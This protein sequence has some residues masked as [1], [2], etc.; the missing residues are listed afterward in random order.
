MRVTKTI[1]TDLLRFS[2]N[3]RKI[4]DE[5]IYTHYD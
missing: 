4:A 1:S 2:M 5:Y 3:T